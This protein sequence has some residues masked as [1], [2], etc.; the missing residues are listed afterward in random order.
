MIQNIK[1]THEEKYLTFGFLDLTDS[2]KF[3]TKYSS[4]FGD[5]VKKRHDDICTEII[6]KHGGIVVGARREYGDAIL[7]TF[8]N[9]RQACESVIEIKEFLTKPQKI[10]DKSIKLSTKGVLVSAMGYVDTV[11]GTVGGG[12]PERC[13]RILDHVSPD[14][15]FLEKGLH[16]SIKSFLADDIIFSDP[17]TLDTRDFGEQTVYEISTKDIGLN[18]FPVKEEDVTP[19]PPPDDLKFKYISLGLACT[20]VILGMFFGISYYNWV[21]T[22]Q[23]YLDLEN[24]LSKSKDQIENKIKNFWEMSAEYSTIEKLNLENANLSNQS[25]KEY[26]DDEEKFKDLVS[27]MQEIENKPMVKYVWL[28][29][30]DCK[31]FLY[32]THDDKLEEDKD[33][34]NIDWCIGMKEYDVYFTS[35]YHSS[36]ANAF[37]TTMVSEIY[38]DETQREIIGYLG[39]AVDWKQVYDTRQNITEENL[40]VIVD[41]HNTIV[42]AC[43]PKCDYLDNEAK[44]QLDN[45]IPE[46]DIQAKQ[47]HVDDFIKKDSLYGMTPLDQIDAGKN[48]KILGDWILLVN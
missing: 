30:P 39:I 2:T 41:H 13:K 10:K 47:F 18:P 19:D 3:T 31:E 36:G 17:F 16:D 14:T 26:L 9:Q 42:F 44:T 37:V 20:I 25:L 1:K 29:T 7:F 40:F 8:D 4:E 28:A 22:I 11:S 27:I 12:P 38:K 46:K 5:D 45:G 6:R 15:I 43:N 24:Y 48:S 33:L 32:Y 34:T 35:S 21:D 23:P